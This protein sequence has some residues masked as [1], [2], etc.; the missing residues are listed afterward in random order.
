MKGNGAERTRLGEHVPLNA[1]GVALAPMLPGVY[2][3]YRGHRLI[4]LGFAAP[5]YSIRQC[6]GE[7]L[8]GERGACT[9]A[10]TE[11]DYE[12]SG[13]PSQL[14]RH[15]MA[16]YMDATGGLMPECNDRQEVHGWLSS[17]G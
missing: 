8:R 7:H 15:Y 17:T 5:G 16:I 6:L 13:S 1:A 2:L 3:L 9:A 14:Y 11:F 10:A 12:S 4:Y